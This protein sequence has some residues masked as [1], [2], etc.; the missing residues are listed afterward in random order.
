MN[1]VPNWPA[2]RDAKGV[3][4]PVSPGLLTALFLTPA[5]T[6]GAI[7]FAVNGKGGQFPSPQTDIAALAAMLGQ[8]SVAAPGPEEL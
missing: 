4:R 5:L 7:G 6:A 2:R 1:A 8:T 3:G